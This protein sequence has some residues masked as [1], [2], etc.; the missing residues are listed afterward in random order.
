VSE[1]LILPMGSGCL[2]PRLKSMNRSRWLFLGVVGLLVF[3]SQASANAGTPLM[4]ATASHLVIG[5][6]LIGVLEGWILGRWF[7]IPR[8]KAILVMIAAN[9]FS[10]WVGGL[11][12]RGAI[13]SALPIDLN[14]GWRWFWIMVGVTYCLTLLLEWPFVA[15]VFRGTPGWM[16][17]T[18]GA[19]FAV[20]SVSYTLLFGWYWLASSTSLYTQTQIVRSEDLSLPE[21]VLVYYID[22]SDGGVYQRGL[23][24]G[25]V[26][27]VLDLKLGQKADRLFV[28]PNA[29]DT[30]RWDLMAWLEGEDRRSPGTVSVRTNLHIDAALDWRGFDED[31][32]TY[33]GTGSN[34]GEVAALAS[35]TNSPWEFWVGSWAA[36]GLRASRKAN[37]EWFRV[38][39]ETPF[40][41]WPVRNAVHLPSDKVI[42][43]LGDDQICGFD[44]VKRQVALLWRGRGAVPII[45]RRGME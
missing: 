33:R 15:A 40:G 20:Q 29:V 21:S 17:R 32:P 41:A 39:Y 28:W 31:P 44:P 23:A 9:Y 27:K 37:D 16:K 36:E 25:E 43:Q 22:P 7:G 10:A 18:M 30:N 45:K 5:N 3:P 35:A 24:G 6:A 1:G 42:F 19:T 34:F 4:W 11:F 14:N 12:I 8:T 2:G 26:K 38:A 13:V